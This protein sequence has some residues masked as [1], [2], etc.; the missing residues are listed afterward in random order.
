MPRGWPC[1]DPGCWVG[2]RPW[3]EEGEKVCCMSSWWNWFCYRN[4]LIFLSRSSPH[5]YNSFHPSTGDDYSDS[6]DPDT[7]DT[8]TYDPDKY[9]IYPHDPY[10]IEV[11]S[12]G[13]GWPYIT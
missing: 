12:Y 5:S 3:K 11:P 13:P 2:G 4:V 9:D 10:T 6:Y 7:Y 1:G 8:D